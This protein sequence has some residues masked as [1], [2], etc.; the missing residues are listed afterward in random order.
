MKI[1]W[2]HMG[3]LEVVMSSVFE[4]L[5]LDYILP[6]PN[7]QRTLELGARYG[8]EFA[9]FPLKTTL[10]NFIEAIEGGAD[11]L[12]MVAG[13]GPCRFGYYAETQRRILNDAGFEF[14]MVP[15]EFEP[16]KIPALVRKLQ[17]L[18]QGHSWISLARAIKFALSKAFLV[19]RLEQQAL[20]Q[21]YLDKEKGATTAALKRC[22]KMVGEADSYAALKRVEEET[23]AM[24]R[25][26]R[27]TEREKIKIGIV[28]EFYLVLEP[29]FNLQVEEQLGYLGAYVERSIYLTDW[30]RPSGENPVA[31]HHDRESEQAAMPYLTHFVGGEGIHS[32]GNTVL[33]QRHGFDGV[34]HL[35]PF[36]CMPET[37][38]KSI[39]PLVSRGLGIPVLSLV[40][41]EMTGKAGVDT[42]LEAFTD[43]A[44]FRRRAREKKITLALQPAF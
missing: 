23:F 38:A 13:R 12:I 29:F 24:L 41:D 14:Q 36:T 6:P 25:S 39:L 3:S 11:T 22:Y 21:R 15:L 33:Y 43:L 2:P 40:I 8:P 44:R 7:T 9:C 30:L 27:R 34:V 42:R 37:I 26:V 31:G 28:G 20:H 19:D 1:S 32:V 35:M 10:G 16:A 18:K 5:H 4:E 17:D